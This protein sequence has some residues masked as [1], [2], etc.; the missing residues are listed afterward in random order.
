MSNSKLMN[1]RAMDSCPI[2]STHVSGMI[3]EPRNKLLPL[4]IAHFTNDNGLIFALALC[5][6][7][8]GF[9]ATCCAQR[10]RKGQR[11]GPRPATP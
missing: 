3:C 8:R 5:R 7:L 10:A 2:P 4:R 1:R 9:A 6:A 11:L